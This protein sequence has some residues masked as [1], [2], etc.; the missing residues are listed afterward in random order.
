MSSPAFFLDEAAARRVLMV[1]AFETGPAT[2]VPWTADDR[3]LVTRLARETTA[4]DAAPERY[5]DE[6]ARHALHLLAPRDKSVSRWVER[7][8]WRPG[9]IL[10]ALLLGA[11]LGLA[12]DAVG[13]SQRINLMAPPVWVVIAWNAIVVLSLLLPASW[14][15]KRARDWLARRLAG[16][17][18]GS[19][20]LQAYGQAWARHG[21][22]LA[23]AR[24][25]LLLHLMAA[26]LA[27][28]L[29]AGLYLRGLV[30]DFRVGWQSTFLDAATVQSV[31]AALLAPAVAL[32]GIAVPDATALEALRVVPGAAASAPAAPWIHLYAAMLA[33]FV[34]LPRL[35]LAAWSGWRSAWLSRR[36]ALPGDD[37][38]FQRLL[39]E[40]RGGIP[41]V[42]VLPHGAAP[43][44]QAALGL[45]ALLA[46][47][48]GPGLQLTVAAPT[49]YGDEEAAER[50]AAEPAT[51]LRLALVDLGATPEDDTHGRFLRALR[52]AAPGVPVLLLADASAFD[53]RFA[54]LPERGAERRRAWQQLAEAQGVSWVAVALDTP[55]LAA[56]E[57]AFEAA[58]AR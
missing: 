54:G 2:G 10:L 52:A 14:V 15:P 35:A 25:A 42:Q 22:P 30:L 1:Q 58:L 40:H 49:P 50:I 37:P 21:W 31:L 28:G 6:R 24:A 57:A 46:R 18:G 51:T 43:T 4:P 16:R 23:V 17:A 47:V 29:A 38:Y 9:W 34:V 5:L 13:G 55:D 3:A 39:R 44:P 45:R 7:R 27:V 41:R 33:L 8:L 56:A 12:V 36:I 53:R 20:P 11:A 32:T 48:L 19:A 26:A